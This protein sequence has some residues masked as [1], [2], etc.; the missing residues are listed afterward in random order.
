MSCRYFAADD[1]TYTA[2]RQTLDAAWGYP[3]PD[4]ATLSCLPPPEECPRD[5]SGRVCVC[6]LSAHAEFTPAAALLEEAI[7]SNA[8]SEITATEYE[9]LFTDPWLPSAP[10]AE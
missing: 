10:E 5:A 2:L 1:A 6:V 4:A 7:A 9:S 8:V 3:R